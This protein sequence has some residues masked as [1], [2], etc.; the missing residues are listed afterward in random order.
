LCFR[1]ESLDNQRQRNYIKILQNSLDAK[2][3]DYGIESKPSFDRAK[4]IQNLMKQKSNVDYYHGRISE[5]SVSNCIIL[6]HGY[7]MNV[8]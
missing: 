3:E 1:E 5:L 8:I 7:R 4:F 2:L 6:N